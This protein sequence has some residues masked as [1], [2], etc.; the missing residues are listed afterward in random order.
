MAQYSGVSRKRLTPAVVAAIGLLTRLGNEFIIV[1]LPLVVLWLWRRRL[2]R[3]AVEV[4]IATL[5]AQLI[6]LIMR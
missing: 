4:L 3:Q 5:G 2:R 6:N 1:A